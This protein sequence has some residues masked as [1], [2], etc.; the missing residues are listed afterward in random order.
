[1]N[2]LIYLHGVQVHWLIYQQI[3]NITTKKSE[4]IESFAQFSIYSVITNHTKK[5][6]TIG[7]NT[8]FMAFVID[9]DIENIDIGNDKM[10]CVVQKAERRETNGKNGICQIQQY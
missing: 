8:P 5:I 2:I 3:S 7:C 9:I 10:L 4:P 1:M 6:D